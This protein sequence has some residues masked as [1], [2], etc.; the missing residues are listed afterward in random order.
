MGDIGSDDEDFN[1]NYRVF[2]E[3][4]EENKANLPTVTNTRQLYRYCHKEI[5]DLVYC[6]EA[7]DSDMHDV[8]ESIQ[9]HLSERETKD[10]VEID[11]EDFV[12]LE[13]F[14]RF[15]DDQGINAINTEY[16]YHHCYRRFGD[17]VHW[18][19]EEP[20]IEN[21]LMEKIKKFSEIPHSHKRQRIE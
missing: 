19:D 11:P 9:R 8:K 6:D 10:G 15:L 2:L 13:R 4:I 18:Q 17:L 12:H 1:A 16:L 5:E 20:K 7:I 3:E 14:K 21:N